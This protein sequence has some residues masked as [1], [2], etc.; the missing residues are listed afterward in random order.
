MLVKKA[1]IKNKQGLHVR[2]AGV[3]SNAMSKYNSDVYIVVNEH[4][5]N[6]K[7]IMHII[8]AAL[9]YDQEIQIECSGD[10]EEQALK[11]AVMIIEMG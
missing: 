10:D 7:S 2:A 11:E 4:Y 6:G 5:I 1:I 3:F 9:K 8:G